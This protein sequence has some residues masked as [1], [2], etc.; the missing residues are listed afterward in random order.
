MYI[1]RLIHMASKFSQFY[2]IWQVWGYNIH[3]IRRGCCRWRRCWSSSAN[4]TRCLYTRL[5]MYVCMYYILIY[6]YIYI[7]IHMCIH[8]Y[9]YIHMLYRYTQVCIHVCIH[10]YI[11]IYI[12]VNMYIYIY[13]YVYTH[14]HMCI[15]PAAGRGAAWPPGG[16]I[17]Y[18][19]L[20]LLS[21]PLLW[22][23]SLL[24]F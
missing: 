23:A 1:N 5:Y 21:L 16:L 4:R 20:C 22:Y 2:R 18:A 10:I 17:Y 13:I 9:I 24:P 12:Y 15:E 19:L 3:S 11:Y 14:T 6:I 7:Y 8:V